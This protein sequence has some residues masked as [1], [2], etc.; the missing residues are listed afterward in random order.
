[1]EFKGIYCANI[2]PLEA[3]GGAIRMDELERLFI[4]LKRAGVAGMVCNGHAGEGELLSR[5]EKMEVVKLA[6]RALGAD[7]PVVAGVHALPTWELIEQVVDA[8]EAGANAVMLCAPPLFA[9]HAD[10]HPDFGIAQIRAVAEAVP[11]MPI[12]LF[13]YSPNNPFY[14]RPEVLARICREIPQ[15]KAIKMATNVDVARYEEEVRAVRAVSRKI[16]LLPANGRTFYYAFQLMP[17]GALSGSAN[18]CP[19]HD[20]ELF[21]AA[22]RGDLKRAKE[23]HDQIFPVFRLVYCDP[24]VYLHIRYKYCAWLLG[25]ISSPAVRSPLV[26]L[27]ADEGSALKEGLRASGLEPVR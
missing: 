14:Y 24:Y 19:A 8:K 20:V 12:V 26:P 2:T 25:K 9:W 21:D 11:D 13:Q 10:R 15:V 3:D 1:M 17:D 23:L 18:F 7:Y 5:K 4:E 6:R 22:R 27:P 16:Y